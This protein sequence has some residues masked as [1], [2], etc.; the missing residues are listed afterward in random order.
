[1]S[2]EEISRKIA[3]KVRPK[4][5]AWSG[6]L[7]IIFQ[8]IAD[9]R[10]AIGADCGTWY[11]NGDYPTPGGNAMANEAFVLYHLKLSGRPYELFTIEQ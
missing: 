9:L 5:V 3:E 8:N 6:H 1:F 10:D 11:F 7:Q 4:D 2:D